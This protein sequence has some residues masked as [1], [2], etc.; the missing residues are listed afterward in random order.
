M[1]DAALAPATG[2]EKAAWLL[3]GCALL[4]LFHFQLSDGLGP[5]FFIS[6]QF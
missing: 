2:P 6:Y 5:Q 4:F 1:N 3:A